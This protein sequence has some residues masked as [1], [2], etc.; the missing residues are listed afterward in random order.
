MLY[1]LSN[2]TMCSF[3]DKG[4]SESD[5]SSEK[6]CVCHTHRNSISPQQECEITMFQQRGSGA[7]KGNK[8]QCT[9]FTSC[10]PLNPRFM[11]HSQE[12]NVSTPHLQWLERE[13]NLCNQLKTSRVRRG[14][15]WSDF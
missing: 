13:L 8:Y 10:K 6:P 4:L 9:G 3:I 2:I 15:H 14:S 1:L 12:I 7:P 5:P 11:G